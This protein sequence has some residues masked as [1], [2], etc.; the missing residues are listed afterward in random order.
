[1]YL[2]KKAFTH[3]NKNVDLITLIN[4]NSLE[5]K[6][7]SFGALLVEL[8]VP[9]RDGILENIVLTHENTENYK[10]NPSLFGA[11]VGR[12]AGRIAN[13]T[14]ILDGCEYHLNKNFGENHGHGGYLGFSYRLWNYNIEEKQDK[15][16]VEFQYT[17]KDR[18]EYYPGN[19]NVKVSYTL[20]DDNLLIVEYR[21]NTDAKTL[22]NLTN[23]SYFNLSGNNRRKV[24]EQYLIVNSDNFLELNNNLIPTG[25]IVNVQGTPMDFRKCKLIGQDI[26][27]DYYQLN[28]TKGYDHTWI[29]NGNEEQ[30]EM[31]DKDSGRKMSVTTTYPSVVIYSYNF[32][33][34]E[35]LKG[36]TLGNIN[37]GICFETQYEPDGINHNNLHSAILTPNEGYYHKTQYKFSTI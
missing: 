26:Q 36:N 31:M 10:T 18:E 6:L 2:V 35:L 19:L 8:S 25:K 4:K 27:S 37:D 12:F 3:N 17:S 7:L 29:L 23:H 5:V 16:I 28:I 11:T 15:T 30:I 13:G 9:D 20:T 32:P 33:N 14:F 22:C 21:A 24:T 1:M 34:N